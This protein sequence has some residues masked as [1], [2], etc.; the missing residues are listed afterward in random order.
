MH[1][2]QVELKFIPIGIS[3][4]LPIPTYNSL[5]TVLQLFMVDKIQIDK[6]TFIWNVISLPI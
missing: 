4:S 1:Q 3:V 2:K 6:L 5:S